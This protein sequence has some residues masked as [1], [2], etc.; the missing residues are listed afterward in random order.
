M[1]NFE[2]PVSVCRHCQNYHLEGRRGGYCTQLSSPVQGCWTACTLA[3]PPFAPSWESHTGFK[4][5]IAQ[6]LWKQQQALVAEQTIK[7]TINS[8]AGPQVRDALENCIQPSEDSEE[9]C[10]SEDAAVQ[11]IAEAK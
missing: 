10:V 6:I 3:I 2:S 7:T 5:E 11:M 4:E 8:V 9:Y 1:N